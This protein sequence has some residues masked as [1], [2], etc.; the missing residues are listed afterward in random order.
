M[1]TNGLTNPERSTYH[2]NSQPNIE[3]V[4]LIW[5]TLNSDSA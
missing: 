1:N 5:G 3:T 4:V 2:G